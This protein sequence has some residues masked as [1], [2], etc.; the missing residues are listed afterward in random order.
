MCQV[1]LAIL[2]DMSLPMFFIYSKIILRHERFFKRK[3]KIIMIRLYTRNRVL[4]KSLQYLYYDYLWFL[5]PG[6]HNW[7]CMCERERDEIIIMGRWN[8][9]DIAKHYAI[10]RM[11]NGL[12][13]SQQQLLTLFEIQSLIWSYVRLNNICRKI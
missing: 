6:I 5:S 10:L 8:Y 7:I 12:Q 9:S 1:C 3:R 4:T 13:A 11:C 2:Y